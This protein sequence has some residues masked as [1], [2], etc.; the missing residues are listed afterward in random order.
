MPGRDAVLCSD[1]SLLFNT[2]T[3]VETDDPFSHTAYITVPPSHRLHLILASTDSDL[4][5]G[6][7]NDCHFC[8]LLARIGSRSDQ[9][10]C[11]DGS[12]FVSSSQRQEIYLNF[13]HWRTDLYHT[14]DIQKGKGRRG[15]NI[16][17]NGRMVLFKPTGMPPA[18]NFNFCLP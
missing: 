8:S 9:V 15:R 18:A 2:E 5:V 10:G 13:Y 16:L 4:A 17:H 14:I 7:M 12:V 1:C 11:E 3:Q 6:S